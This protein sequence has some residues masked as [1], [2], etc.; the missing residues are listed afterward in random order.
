[1]FCLTDTVTP[2][3]KNRIYNYAK[4]KQMQTLRHCISD[5]LD[6]YSAARKA[7]YEI[8]K[9]RQ[10]MLHMHVTTLADELLPNRT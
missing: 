6:T 3:G 9:M 2:I 10:C 1:M 4:L 5:K 8:Y 7:N